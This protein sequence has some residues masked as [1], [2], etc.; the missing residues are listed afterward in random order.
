MN[1]ATVVVP[2]GFFLAPQAEDD[3]ARKRKHKEIAERLKRGDRVD[4]THTGQ[5]LTPQEANKE[6]GEKLEVPK[7][8]LKAGFYW[9]ERDPSLLEAEK[10]AMRTYLPHFHMDKLD[11]GR[12]Y[13]T[14]TLNPNG[15]A[16]GVWTVMA[17]YDH[18]HP[19]YSTWGGSVKVYSIKPDLD[20]LQNEV[21][22]RGLPHVARDQSGSL[23]M[24]TTG[25]EDVHK[26]FR[27]DGVG[28][29]TS[30]ATS[31]SWATKWIWMVEGW[32]AGELNEEEVFEHVY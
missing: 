18:N 12:L 25:E 15:V 8:I 1:D 4:M 28:A 21:G 5:V 11:D 26:G 9:Y 27:P 13:W 29:A 23:Y 31:L 2:R 6:Q 19:Q 30:A 20:E 3:E 7:A 32:L 22:G 14:G 24:C 10:Q 16:G 17:I